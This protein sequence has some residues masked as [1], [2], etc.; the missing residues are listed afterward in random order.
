M[1]GIAGCL[2][3]ALEADP[4][5]AWLTRALDRISHRGPDDDGVYTDADVALGFRRLS[6]LDL[7]LAGH[8]PM[9]SADGR[10]WMLFN[11]EIYNYVEM[12]AELREQRSEEH[13]SELQSPV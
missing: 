9:R 6:I 12:A 10:F 3:L 4:D 5:Q 11:G 8:Q 13:T 2:A 1:C 7:S